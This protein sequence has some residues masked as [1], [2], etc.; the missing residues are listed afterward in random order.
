MFIGAD[1]SLIWLIMILSEDLK[2]FDFPE[3]L[4]FLSQATIHIKEPLEVL[5]YTLN[6]VKEKN[7]KSI[8][9]DEIC[10][11]GKIIYEEE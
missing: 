2:R 9:W 5:G 10:A 11:T 8:F 3:R 4:V 7:G 6:E 1:R